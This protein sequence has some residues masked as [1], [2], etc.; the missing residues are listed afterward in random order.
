MDEVR[1]TRIAIVCE[2]PAD[3]RMLSAL[4]D[5]VLVAE[6]SGDWLSEEL[7]ESVRRFVGMDD[8]AEFE[9][10]RALSEKLRPMRAFG[11][12]QGEVGL[13]YA[14]RARKTLTLLEL[15]DSPPDVVILSIDADDDADRHRGLGQARLVTHW[16]FKAVLI[17]CAD[18]NRE[19][20]LLSGF[21]PTDESERAS[22]AALTTELGFDPTSASHR[23]ASGRI[24]HP[25]SSKRVLAML[26]ADE[27][28]REEQCLRQTSLDALRRCGAANGL[29]NFLDHV[30]SRILPVLEGRQE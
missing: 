11:H 17:A 22:L 8:R 20:W 15:L 19:A 7:L 18:P 4:V 9:V 3:F 30:R 13:P 23:L 16:S 2:A 6:S 5:R 14:H 10:W 29:A 25:R 24:Q 28:D 26:S 21:D 1:P 12:F 27:K